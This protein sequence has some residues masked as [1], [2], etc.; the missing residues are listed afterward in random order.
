MGRRKCRL[1]T[2]PGNDGTGA[3]RGAFADLKTG[4][5]N[6]VAA[7]PYILFD[8]NGFSL[9]QALAPHPF[10]R[11]RVES[12]G[13]EADVGS[14]V[15]VVANLDGAGVDDGAVAPDEDV[16]SYG[17]IVAVVAGEGRLN[18]DVIPDPAHV[19]DRGLLGRRQVNGL[20]GHQDLAE[21]S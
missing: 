9:L 13:E 10:G 1:V 6:H 15:G 21:Q 7:D 11:I 5:D 17:D 3:Y 19:S 4:Q 18:H 20:L 2:Y 14:Y 8:G 12:G 16:L